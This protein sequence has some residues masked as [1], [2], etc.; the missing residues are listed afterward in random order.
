MSLDEISE[1]VTVDT[2]ASSDAS[3]KNI[4]TREAAFNSYIEIEKFTARP[5]QTF[6]AVAY[7]LTKEISD[8]GSRGLWFFLGTFNSIKAVTKY[9]GKVIERTKIRSVYAMH[10]CTWQDINSD[11]KPDRTKMVPIDKESRIRQQH[12]KEYKSTVKAYEKE[13]EVSDQIEDEC[14]REGELDSVEYYTRQWYLLIKNTSTV[15]KLEG[16]LK[17]AKKMQHDRITKLKE[18]YKNHPEHED[19][20]LKQL[21][22]R[23]PKRG[24]T[25]LLEALKNGSML[26]KPEIFPNVSENNV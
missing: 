25:D 9:V 17:Q 21:E 5:G 4:I 20:W 8:E 13:K 22:E 26:L 16:D 6:C 2:P 10:T 3:Y 15:E 14:F 23:L 7:F 1:S 24:E 19:N 11:F 12:E 18:A